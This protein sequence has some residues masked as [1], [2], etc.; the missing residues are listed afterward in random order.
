M[1]Y[2]LAFVMTIFL[3]VFI[4]MRMCV[5]K[6][7][8][9]KSIKPAITKYTKGTPGY[10]IGLGIFLFLIGIL[11]TMQGIMGYKYSALSSKH[12]V[13]NPP[14]GI[15]LMSSHQS[16]RSRHSTSGTNS[17]SSTRP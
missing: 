4:I 3:F 12:P 1:L 6:W 11:L 8:G 2:I 15:Q 16:S 7:G 17:E 14:K 5:G 13:T 10:L 9:Y